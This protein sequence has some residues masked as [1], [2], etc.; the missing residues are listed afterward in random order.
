MTV[1][2]SG[3]TTDLEVLRGDRSGL[4]QVLLRHQG[5]HDGGWF[6]CRFVCV[7]LCASLVCV[8]VCVC[9]CLCLCSGSGERAVQPWIYCSTSIL[10]AQ[11]LE[12]SSV[13]T[14]IVYEDLDTIRYEIKNPTTGGEHHVPAQRVALPLLSR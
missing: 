14:L 12:L 3:E 9:V 6:R 8:C 1:V 11:A 13:E 2:P 7:C 10:S 5:H 4:G